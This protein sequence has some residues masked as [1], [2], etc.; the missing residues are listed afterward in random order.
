MVVIL[1]NRVV[2]CCRLIST[3]RGC[4]SLLIELTPSYNIMHFFLQVLAQGDAFLN[5]SVSEG[6]PLAIIEASRAGLVVIAT[7]VGGENTKKNV[8]LFMNC[9]KK[10]DKNSRY[11]PTAAIHTVNLCC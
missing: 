5:S 9:K 6:L 10:E 11:V 1:N 2:Y 8:I 3:R 7:D 4:G